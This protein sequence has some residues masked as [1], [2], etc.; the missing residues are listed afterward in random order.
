M[1]PF[2]RKI[3]K[4]LSNEQQFLKYSRYA[5]GEIVLVV[6][7]ILIALSINNWNEEQKEEVLEIQFLKSIKKDLISD[8]LY[9]NTR[10]GQ[11]E[12][13]INN[14]YQFVHNA[15][16]E[17]KDLEEFTELL[18]LLSWNSENFAPNK[19]AFFEILNSSQLN[20]FKNGQLKDDFISLYNDYE[21]AAY[22]MDE[23][24]KFTASEL[25]EIGLNFYKYWKP[26]SYIFDEAYLFNNV[27]WHYINDS[28]TQE[29]ITLEGLAVLYSQKH[30]VFLF[31]F[32]DLRSKVNLMQ[33]DIEREIK[34]R[35]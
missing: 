29:F 12:K 5:F 17:Q 32:Y 27:D 20:I 30:K 18:A 6:I 16:K 23:F 33:K 25:G 22:H 14:H 21:K 15:H 28:N 7:G 31:Y 2:F 13:L 19:S 3:R 34:R 1:I 24:N 4:K 11:S 26:Y 10:I 35:E 8:S 9:L